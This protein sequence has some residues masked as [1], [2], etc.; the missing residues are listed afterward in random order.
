MA[1]DFDAFN[2]SDPLS[3]QETERRQQIERLRREALDRTRIE[4][5]KFL[6]RKLDNLS[7]PQ[8]GQTQFDFS[9][10]PRPTD[11]LSRMNS[12][13][14]GEYSNCKIAVQETLNNPELT[15]NRTKVSEDDVIVSDW[16]DKNSTKELEKTLRPGDVLDFRGSHYAIYEGSGSVVQ[17]PGWGEKPERVSLRSVL[18]Y[19][20][21]PT[22]IISA[23]DEPRPTDKSKLPAVIDAASVAS[24][25]ARTQADDPRPKGLRRGLGSLKRAPWMALAQMTW[26]NLTPKQREVAKQYGKDAY[27]SFEDAWKAASAWS[28]RN[29]FPTGVEGGL[30]WV[31]DRLGFSDPEGAS[32]L[33][34]FQELAD[35][36][37][38]EPETAMEE[39]RNVL[40]G[41]VLSFLIE[42]TGDLTNR[43]A[44]Q[45]DPNYGYGYNVGSKVRN[46][47]QS[48]RSEYG[49]GKEYRENI[50][51]TAGLRGISEKALQDASTKALQ[52]YADAHKKLKVYNE[53]QKW[54]RDAAV[55]LGEQRFGDA[56]KLLSKLENLIK[57]DPNSTLGDLPSGSDMSEAY[58]E[59]A[60]KFDPDYEGEQP[61]PNTH[62]D[63]S[64]PELI[65]GYTVAPAKTGSTRS[66]A[67]TREE[68][69]SRL[70]SNPELQKVSQKALKDLGY[71]K[72]TIPLFR[73]TLTPEGGFKSEGVVSTSLT[74][75]SHL[76]TIKYFTEG[77]ISPFGNI[78]PRLIRYDVPIKKVI[79]YLPAFKDQI[80]RG[81][82][83]AVKA[84]GMGQR[85]LK[86]FS[87]V[88]DPARHAKNLLDKQKEVLV[89]VTGIPPTFMKVFDAQESTETFVD[90]RSIRMSRI[91]KIGRG[92][93]KTPED[94]RRDMGGNETYFDLEEAGKLLRDLG[95]DRFRQLEN[96]QMQK[97]IEH[98]KKFFGKAAGGFVDKPLYED[99]RMVG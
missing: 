66:D 67:V 17:V 72:G 19:W 9:G 18:D 62:E 71:N 86:G 97:E 75:E 22:Q 41:G 36:Q 63:L 56:E 50:K 40:G 46:V 1:D 47:L 42:H 35:L 87:K 37:R 26:E 4:S 27:G 68:L 30:Q 54:A 59:A 91:E 70:R 78:T 73:V 76:N 45:Y 44:D 74:P 11:Y 16:F 92:R 6:Q 34:A 90:P 10:E 98:Y 5:E 13:L 33:K 52:K 57:T 38:Q 65:T 99:A 20:S 58:R 81:V 82:N 96:E 61:R 88:G 64:L 83:K 3:Q 12:C 53:P 39:A 95:K 85:D 8:G 84:K 43:M 14:K 80:K 69:V 51:T 31:M 77:K 55:A 60:G 48:L 32:R 7:G 23:T 2:N 24:Q 89:D 28:E 21:P 94:Y 29:R 25:L 49:F 15:G 93:I 79:G